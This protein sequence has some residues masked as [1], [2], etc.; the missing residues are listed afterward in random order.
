MN[1]KLTEAQNAQVEVQQFQALKDK[2]TGQISS[3]VYRINSTHDP[4]IQKANIAL[5]TA[6]TTET[7]KYSE[8]IVLENKMTDLVHEKNY[9][10][11]L[12]KKH[13][14]NIIAVAMD[15]A[16]IN[17]I[18][19]DIAKLEPKRANAWLMNLDAKADKVSAENN[20]NSALLAK[21]NDS[22]YLDQ[23]KREKIAATDS[24]N[25]WKIAYQAATNVYNDLSI[26]LE[27]LKTT[28]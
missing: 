19:L 8:Y 20:Y 23:L 12:I 10:L 27:E 9:F 17:I 21:Q 1:E 16:N 26:Q 11:D 4:L 13:P 5:A 3:E 24:L 14:W 18:D 7:Q 15:M 25:M 2:L 22:T 28:V 6:K